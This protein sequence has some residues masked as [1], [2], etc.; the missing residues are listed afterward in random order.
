MEVAMGVAH[1]PDGQHHN[2]MIPSSYTRVEVHTVKPQF[3]QWPTD[4]PT[5]DGQKFLGEV[6]N[7]FI[8]WHKK[9]I[10]LNASSLPAVEQQVEGVIEEGEIFS[11][12]CDYLHEMPH[13]S[14]PPSNKMSEMPQPSEQCKDQRLHTVQVHEQ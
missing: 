6:M 10:V 8:P 2:N 11:L 14:P 3:M 1:P 5:L 4:H 9:D 13:S 7:Q 12:A